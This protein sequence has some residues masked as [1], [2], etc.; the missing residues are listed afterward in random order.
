MKSKKLLHEYQ[1]NNVKHILDNPSCGLILDMG[2]G[3]TVIT[4][5]AI[6]QLMYEELDISRV[7]VVAPKRVAENVWSDEIAEWEH[8]NHLTY[9][10]ITGTANQRK[11]ALTKKS[12][13]YLIGRDNIAWLCSQY[14][15]LYLPFD[16]I[17]M[18]ESSSFK[19][20]KSIRFKALKKTI[21]SFSRRVILTGTPSPNGLLDLWS[22]LYLLDKGE[23]LEKTISD[24]RRIYFEP[25]KRNQ[26]VIFS[27]KLKKG[28]EK[29]ISSK[30]KDICISMRKEDYLKL[31][32]RIDNFIDVKMDLETQ[33]KY[34]EFEKEQVLEFFGKDENGDDKVITAINAAALS[35][36]LLQYANGAVYDENKD[37]HAVHDMK[38]KAVEE[39]IEQNNGK[40]I[41]IAWTYRHDM[42]RLHERLKKYKP[43]DL[44][45]TKD[46]KDWNDGKIQVLMMHP[47]SGGHGLNLQKGGSTIIWF[48]QTWSLEL[49]QQL[50]ARLHRQGQKDITIVHH[51]I[52]VRTIDMDV[53]NAITKKS[54]SQ[55]GLINAV[56]ARIQKYAEFR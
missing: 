13:I 33:R 55:D 43:R 45:E 6:Q 14:G 30:I 7:L 18:D 28:A 15:G 32:D 26:Q 19:N 34:D 54:R 29:I 1:V 40:P 9:T 22:Q 11:E 42:Y 31:P 8:L 16:M 48:G 4:L 39:I 21:S 47:A 27:Y 38:L 41:L 20:P 12:D 36:K 2:L 44:K 37:W 3:K 5:T 10:I 46:I 53:R 49:Y 51:L 35:N 50:N 17:V 56:K 24:Y 25:N 52:A 23:R